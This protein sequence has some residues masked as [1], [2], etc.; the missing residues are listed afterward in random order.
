MNRSFGW[1]VADPGDRVRCPRRGERVDLERCLG[2]NWLLDLDR[3]SGAPALLCAA[4]LSAAFPATR[5]TADP[6]D[7]HVD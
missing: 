5:S 2:C 4:T 1:I 7:H 6:T 3:T